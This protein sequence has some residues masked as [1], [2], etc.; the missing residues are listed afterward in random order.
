MTAP[1]ELKNKRPKKIYRRG[2]DDLTIPF[3]S[4]VSA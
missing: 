4:V 2:E 3:A 1:E